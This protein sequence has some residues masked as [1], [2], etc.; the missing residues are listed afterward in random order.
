MN[1]YADNKSALELWS[2]A[3]QLAASLQASSAR[4]SAYEM[5]SRAAS[6]TAL[7]DAAARQASV[8]RRLSIGLS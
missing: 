4:A 3:E 2:Q 1:P 8:L 5:R 7:A 6:I